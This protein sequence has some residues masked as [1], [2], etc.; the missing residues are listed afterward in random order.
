MNRFRK[1]AAWIASTLAVVLAATGLALRT[2]GIRHDI[3]RWDEYQRNSKAAGEDLGVDS[4]QPPFLDRMNQIL[5][6]SRS[7]VQKFTY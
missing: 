7:K 3:E 6:L 2:A 5:A 1:N 4:W